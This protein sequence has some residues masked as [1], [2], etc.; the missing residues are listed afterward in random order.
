VGASSFSSAAGTTARRRCRTV[1]IAVPAK[2]KSEKGQNPFFDD[3]D[4]QC[5]IVW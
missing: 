4:E 5:A 3:G 2:R 1:A